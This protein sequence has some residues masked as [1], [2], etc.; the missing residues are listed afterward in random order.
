MNFNHQFMIIH[1]VPTCRSSHAMG[2]W[3]EAGNHK[4]VYP[5]NAQALEIG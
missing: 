3:S 5:E 4:Y 1:I 2:I